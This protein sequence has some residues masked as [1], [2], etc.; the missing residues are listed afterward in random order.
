MY[1]PDLISA[2]PYP[3][4]LVPPPAQHVALAVFVSSTEMGR[5]CSG[6]VGDQL[7]QTSYLDQIKLIFFSYFE[8][9]TY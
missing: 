1:L 4:L 9:Y 5:P 2:L 3:L 8:P 6:G 7:D